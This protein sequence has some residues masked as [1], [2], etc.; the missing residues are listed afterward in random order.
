M[1]FSD[2]RGRTFDRMNNPSEGLNYLVSQTADKSNGKEKERFFVVV[3][4]DS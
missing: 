2:G 4:T 3:E 1:E